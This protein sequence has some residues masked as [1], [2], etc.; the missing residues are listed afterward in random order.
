MFWQKIITFF[1]IF[2][3]MFLLWLISEDR[4]K[5]PV[6]IIIWGLILQFALGF[7][8]LNVPWG[9]SFFEWLGAQISAFL[10]FSMKGAYFLFGSIP[11]ASKQ[12]IFGFQFAIIV[13]ATV[14]FFSSFVS[15]LYYYGIMQKVVYGMAWIMQKTMKTSGTESLSAASNVFLGQ[16]EAPLI[17]RYYLPDASRSEIHTIMVGGFATIAGGVMAAYVQMGIPAQ[18]LITASLISVPGGLMLSKIVVPATTTGKSLKEIKDVET[19]KADNALVALTDGAGDG[20]RLSL[21]IMAMLIAFVSI[22]AI[23]DQLFVFSHNILANFG[24][25]W[26]PNSLRAFLG[27]LFSP[28]AFLV[29]IPSNEAQAFG[30]LLGTKVS[31]NEFLAFADLGEMINAGTISPRTAKLAAFAICGF[32]NFSSIA[33]QIGG[34]GALA[35]SKKSEI[36]QLGFKAMFVG[37]IVNILTAMIASLMI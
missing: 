24:W 2:L 12:G 26:F 25:T 10:N 36:A 17:I 35:P 9:V 8:I 20:L 5:F 22:I 19:P 37:A 28:F 11:D 1:G 4:K 21:N 34:L 30:S 16:T 33:I 18:D 3:L 29:G 6:R 32:A 7:F 15:I 31:I 14:V 23:V 13:S 27:I